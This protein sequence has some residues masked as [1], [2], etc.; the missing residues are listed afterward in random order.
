MKQRTQRP[1]V[2]IFVCTRDRGKKDDSCGHFGGEKVLSQFKKRIKDRKLQDKVRV[3]PS[4]CIDK[5]SKGPNVLV[6]PGNVWA[7]KVDGHDV[8]ALLDEALERAEA[9]GKKSRRD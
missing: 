1:P 8:D 7:C 2:T 9:D 4:G 5:C 6:F 3:Y